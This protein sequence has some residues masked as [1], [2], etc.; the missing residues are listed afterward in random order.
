M[1]RGG[2]KKGGAKG[3]VKITG[4]T[5]AAMKWE[6][7]DEMKRL[8]NQFAVALGPDSMGTAR[9]KLKGAMMR[10]AVVIRD[11]AKD[12]APSRTGALRNSIIA[13][14]GP[15]NKPGV[16]VMVLRYYGRFIERG[17]SKMTAQPF[18]RPAIAATRPMVANLIAEGLKPIIEEMATELAYH[19]PK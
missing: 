17:T 5:G 14:K 2:G 3:G 6:G 18:F 19:P 7:V 8:F 15:D 11:E 13:T 12:L 10:A 9:D 4:A 16:V 1:A